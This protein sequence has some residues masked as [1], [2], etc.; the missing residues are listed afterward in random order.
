MPVDVFTHME[1]TWKLEANPFPH[2]AVRHGADEPFSEEVF[3]AERAEFISKFVR[4]S[5]QGNRAIGF[6]WSQGPGGDTGYGKTT[7]MLRVAQEI[8]RDLGASTLTETGMREERIVP[9][10]AAYSNLNNLNASGLYPVLFDAVVFTARNQGADQSI[11][12]QARTKII[13]EI[14]DESPSAIR[15]RI[16]QARMEIAPNS[17]PLRNELVEAF[18]AAGGEG[19]LTTLSEVSAAA[20][21]RNGL[22]YLDFL[23]TVLAAAGINHVFLF[24]DQLE[25][26]ATN[27]AIGSAKRS[28]EI[29]R[30]RDLLETQPYASRVHFVLTFHNTAARALERFWAINRLPRFE[31][32]ADNTSAIVVLRGVTSDEQV[33]ALLRVWLEDKRISPV[34]DDLLPFDPTV[35]SVL[36]RVSQGRVGP[37]LSSAHELVEAGSERGLPR[38]SGEFAAEYFEGQIPSEED[39]QDEDLVTADVD[40]LLG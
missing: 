36:R 37:L 23:I 19:V 40:D 17:V 33:A 16:A 32:A 2:E 15:R 26:L 6:L 25:D 9:I 28:R 30:I 4:G 3:P 11:F 12:D 39:Q 22:Q 34:E 7:L 21:L 20:R 38:I 31:I 14:G 35:L 29:G 8:N 18:A 10:A 5:I 1:E 24:I 27:R 13:D